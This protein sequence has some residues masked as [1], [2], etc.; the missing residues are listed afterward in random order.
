MAIEISAVICTYNRVDYLQKAIRSLVNQ[1][2][3]NAKY[4][5]IIIDNNS[6]DGT[7][8]N[9]SDDF[10]ACENLKYYLEP[11]QGL[12]SA[13]N[14]GWQIAKGKYVAYLDDDAVANPNWLRNIL[15]AFNSTNSLGA[16]GG[17][18]DPIWE[19]ERPDWLIDELLP[20]LTVVDWYEKPTLLDSRRYVPGANMAFPKEILK[21]LG[22]FSTD[23]GRKK[24]NL[25]SN[26]EIGLYKLINSQ[27]LNRLYDP[28][29]MVK[30][31]V[32][33]NRI[34]QNYFKRRLY[35]QGISN[36]VLKSEESRMNM[37]DKIKEAYK[38]FKKLI[39]DYKLVV[40][41]IL[42]KDNENMFARKLRIMGNAGRVVGYLFY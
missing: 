21:E 5:I 36:A 17:K 31:H 35:W 18:I 33:S 41:I 26:E 23:L 27:G 40:R 30:H 39:K 3:E 28:E 15:R 4:E 38:E 25:L 11:V 19:S 42:N 8:K 32:S 24:Q 9:V 12:S 14:T 16:V 7:K 37:L 22:G 6:T 34:N 10:V 2:L 13:R 20:F 29:I 1:S